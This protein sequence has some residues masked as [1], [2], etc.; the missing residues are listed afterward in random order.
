MLLRET[1]PA[2]SLRCLFS[3]LLATRPWPHAPSPPWYIGFAFEIKDLFLLHKMNFSKE[4][5]ISSGKTD[6]R[7]RSGCDSRSLR[8]FYTEFLFSLLLLFS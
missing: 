7:T 5:E 3:R 1:F 8:V 6:Y 2:Q 4:S